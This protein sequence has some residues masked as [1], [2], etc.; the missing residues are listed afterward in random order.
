MSYKVEVHA[1]GEWVGN[2]IRL[3][4]NQE[5]VDYGHDL[6]C[7]WFVPD[8]YRVVES[9]EPVNYKWADGKLSGIP[10]TDVPAH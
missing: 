5:A 4:T 8:D 7:R 6:L 2:A 9:D 1:E 3:A 10:A